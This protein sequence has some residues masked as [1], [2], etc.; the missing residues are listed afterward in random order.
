MV[1]AKRFRVPGF[2]RFRPLKASVPA[3]DITV[4]TEDDTEGTT[5][6]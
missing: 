5:R 1:F 4:R 6:C 2:T 3:M